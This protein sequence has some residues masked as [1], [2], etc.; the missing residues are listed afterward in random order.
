M[1]VALNYGPKARTNCFQHRGL[2]QDV[3]EILTRMGYSEN[4]LVGYKL[5]N[6]ITTSISPSDE[7]DGKISLSRTFKEEDFLEFIQELNKL[8][9]ICAKE[10]LESSET[11]R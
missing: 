9:G 7:Y 3:K 10:I 8:E 1:Q 6:P 11:K 2:F 4:E 5:T